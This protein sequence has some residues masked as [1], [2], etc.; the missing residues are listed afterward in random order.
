[1]K[2]KSTQQE[3]LLMTNTSFSQRQLCEK[4]IPESNKYFSR[5]EQLEDAC[6]NGLLDEML[7]GIIEKSSSGKRLHLRQIRPAK[8]FLEIEL[9]EYPLQIEQEF[10]IDPYTFL[11]IAFYS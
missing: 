9:C 2:T 4:D 5:T 11:P 8:S 6:W 7:P 1:M 10:S 3:I